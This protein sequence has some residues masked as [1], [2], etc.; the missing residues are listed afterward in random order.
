[1][2]PDNISGYAATIVSLHQHRAEM[3][4]LSQNAREK[5]RHEFSVTAMTDRWLAA[6]PL[7]RLE[8]S[9]PKR[10]SIRPILSAQNKWRFSAPMRVVRRSLVRFRR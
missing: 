4:Q 2:D 3:R 6:L 9:W 8:R 7:P 10:W 1:V 5:V